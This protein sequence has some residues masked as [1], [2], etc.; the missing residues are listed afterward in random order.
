MPTYLG[1]LGEAGI[2]AK[3]SEGMVF[4]PRGVVA[5]VGDDC[6]VVE[7]GGD[8]VW[9]VTTDLLFEGVH[10]LFESATPEEVGHKAL[11]V[12]LSDIAA[13]GGE[14]RHAFLSLAL[15][16]SLD[17]K[18][19]EGF[20]S[21]FERLAKRHNVNLLGGD[22]SRSKNEL[23]IS[24]T[25]VGEAEADQ[26]LYRKGARAGDRVYVTGT[27][28]DSA[29]GLE[30]LLLHGVSGSKAALERAHLTPEPR[31]AEGRFLAQSG[32][33]TSC[34][35]LS[36]GLATDLGHIARLSGAGALLRESDL[37]FS[38]EF[39]SETGEDR[40]RA[41][42]LALG[43]G[44]D[45]QLCFTVDPERAQDLE[46]DYHRSFG[47]HIHSIGGIISEME[48]VWLDEGK[49]EP[50]QLPPGHDHF[51]EEGGKERS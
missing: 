49:E 4:H 45:Y 20:R 19:L 27:L 13:M 22:L 48:G 33:V 3:L 36:D 17:E 51:R 50:R 1:N 7:A 47:D 23:G 43:G 30:R 28:G 29:A 2:I 26:V 10:F 16:A 5:G 25:V 41:L 38:K 15:T 12:N 14:P 44:E 11:A 9:L 40:Q 24:V 39:R 8:R 42:R 46:Q 35:D 37:P 32:A 34:I 6:A 18:F 31:V 21:G